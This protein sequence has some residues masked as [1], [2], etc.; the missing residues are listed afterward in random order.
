MALLP[1]ING[2]PLGVFSSAGPL[3]ALLADSNKSNRA[4]VIILLDGGN[5]GLNTII[6]LDQYSKLYEARRNV[7]ID[8]QKV[9]P[10][11]NSTITGMHPAMAAVQKMYNEKNATI[12]QGVGYPNPIFSHFR[13]SDMLLTGTDSIVV[14][15]TG[16]LGR[17]I[18]QDFPSFP[19]GFPNE[20]HPDPIALT[21]GASTSKL[22]QGPDVS[23]GI[24]ITNTSE[25]YNLVIG[26][27]EPATQT[28]A[29][30]ALDFM[31]TTAIETNKYMARVKIA[32]G[33]QKNLSKTY[34]AAGENTLADQLKIVAQMIGGGLQT[35]LYLVSMDGFDT[36]GKQV[37]PKETHLGV[38]AKLLSAVS[39]AVACFQD[40][41]HLMNKQDDVLSMTISEFGRRIISNASYGTDHGSSAP[42]MLFGTKLKGGL[43][44]TNPVIPDV[45]NTNDNLPLQTDF[46]TVYRSVLKGWL[47]VQ[48]DKLNA[49]L[50]GTFTELDLFRS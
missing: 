3:A 17:L 31:R 11:Y 22:F 47:D 50:P 27:Y 48:D 23:M 20:T 35:K 7:L 40:D 29:G 15:K 10:L 28:P 1:M 16:W 5:D 4:L 18:H 39:E 13:A 30:L 8:E 6:P 36:H 44:G 37:N 9:L 26:H 21:I 33:K 38:H 32:A 12:I 42:V 24:S 45:V 2:L 34:P 43:V 19:T 14:E 49:I 46:R 41:L 25:F